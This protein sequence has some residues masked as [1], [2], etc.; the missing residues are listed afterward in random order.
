[1]ITDP[2]ADMLTRVRNALKRRHELVEIPSSKMKLAIAELFKREGFIK[3]F[4][5]VEY[6]KQG[7]I[8]IELTYRNQKQPTINGLR[9]ISKP[10][11]RIYLGYRDIKPVYNG[12]GVAILS[13]PQGVMTDAVAREKKVGG[14]FLL[15]IW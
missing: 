12:T 13:T 15:T 3:S 5:E 4:R 10:S 14:E 7:K 1:M 2:I 6:K 8:V 9:R 11:R